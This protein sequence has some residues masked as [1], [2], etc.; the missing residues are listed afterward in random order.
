MTNI[1]NN[2]NNNCAQQFNNLNSLLG[3]ITLYGILKLNV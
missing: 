1:N 2:N 3:F